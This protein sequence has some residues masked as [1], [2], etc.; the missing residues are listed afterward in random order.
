MKLKPFLYS[1]YQFISNLRQA[2]LFRRQGISYLD[3]IRL[4]RSNLKTT[5]FLSKEIKITGS[6]WFLH[7]IEE[8]FCDKQYYFESETKSPYI[9]DCGSNIGLSVIYFKMLF[10]DSTIKCFEPDPDICKILGENLDQFNFTDVEINNKA[11]SFEEGKLNFEKV[12]DLGGKITAKSKHSISVNSIRLKSL[13]NGTV[14]FLKIDIEGAEMDVLR[15]CKNNL[16]DVK[17]IF[18][19]YHSPFNEKQNLSELIA[20][21]E[22]SGFRIY[23]KEAWENLKLP[24]VDRKNDFYDL[25]LNIYGY[26]I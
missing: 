3:F 6:F 13:L 26:R 20:I 4:K 24:Y 2:Y 18:V 23:I 7:G 22:D 8:I 15:D 1:T 25:Q 10:P 5:K 21:L 9:I 17:N 12:G 14:D 11:I 16:S 19:E